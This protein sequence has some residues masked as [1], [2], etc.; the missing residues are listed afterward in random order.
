MNKV[1]EYTIKNGKAPSDEQ[2]LKIEEQVH[3]SRY[4]IYDFECDTTSTTSVVN[5]HIP[6]H[7]EIDNTHIPNHV[8]IDILS[9]TDNYN[10]D[11]C[12]R[13]KK[14]FT[15]YDTLRQFCEWLLNDTNANG[16]TV[17]AHNQSGYDGR[18]ILQECVRRGLHPDTYIRS[19]SR[20]LYMTFRKITYDLLIV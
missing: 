5:T 10:Y 3:T 19:G 1:K 17:I 4:V 7:V 12:L 6:N 14:S 2:M 8:E 18:F 15:G 9:V 20:I 16:A 13:L 11:H